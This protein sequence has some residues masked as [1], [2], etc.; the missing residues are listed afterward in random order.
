MDQRMIEGERFQ[1]ES[2]GVC[3]RSGYVEKEYVTVPTVLGETDQ[4]EV[5]RHDVG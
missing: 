2:E 5:V 3:G 1:W 4:A